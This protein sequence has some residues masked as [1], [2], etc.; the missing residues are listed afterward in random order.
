MTQPLD[1]I[2][3]VLEMAG[4]GNEIL[5]I[6]GDGTSGHVD[7]LWQQA[8]TCHAPNI[9]GMPASTCRAGSSAAGIESAL[10]ISHAGRRTALLCSSLPLL[11]GDLSPPAPLVIHLLQD[12]LQL[13]PGR[14]CFQLLSR[15]PQ[16]A[17]DLSAICHRTAELSL[18]PGVHVCC[19][20]LSDRERVM[21]ET[22]DMTTLRRYIGLA[23][24]EIE[25]PTAAQRGVFGDKRRRIPC[26]APG[27]PGYSDLEGTDAAPQMCRQAMQ[28]FS[29]LTGRAYT[30][31]E[32][33]D[34]ASADVILIAPGSACSWLV[35]NIEQLRAAAG[36]AVGILNPTLLTPFPGELITAIVQRKKGVV[37]LT[38]NLSPDDDPVLR[39]LRVSFD[40][41]IANG[42]S[43]NIGVVPHPQY[44]SYTTTADHPPLLTISCGS[45]AVCLDALAA[46]VT[47]LVRGRSGPCHIRL[48][49]TSPPNLNE[50]QSIDA[51]NL[52]L[53][54]PETAVTPALRQSAVPDEQKSTID[55]EAA[56]H[57]LRAF[58]RFGRASD[59]VTPLSDCEPLTP[60]LFY[61]GNHG[62]GRNDVDGN[63]LPGSDATASEIL[64]D[65]W[66]SMWQE[67][68]TQLCI[69]LEAMQARL[70]SI[71]ASD[72]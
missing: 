18:Y 43:G 69:E 27:I 62:P 45:P 50:Q 38:G 6:A 66:K 19:Q 44:P 8:L 47:R 29:Q 63:L 68:K 25:T 56:L 58:Y 36:C 33:I 22:V 28:E 11:P 21:I 3:A 35:S 15:T 23:D 49:P 64:D 12:R 42:L 13:L 53:S 40:K 67:Q 54:A 55:D 57:A 24:D 4:A 71:L 17:Y 52:T 37:L 31:V 34:T 2:A 16:Q 65:C 26:S 51:S 41:A 46:A 10:A 59:D 70:M 61:A 7:R 14:D 1:S 9:S 30:L 60:A 32:E 39:E 5:A 72:F 48:A 20:P